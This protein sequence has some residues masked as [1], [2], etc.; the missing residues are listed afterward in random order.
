M[1]IV[2]LGVCFFY[3]LCS[4]TPKLPDSTEIED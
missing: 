4:F 3:K 1:S 2:V